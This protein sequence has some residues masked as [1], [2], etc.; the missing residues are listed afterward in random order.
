VASGG[1]WLLATPT[2][3]EYG[4][5]QAERPFEILAP[6]LPPVPWTSRNMLVERNPAETT[7]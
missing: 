1:F 2:R 5:S 7:R 6:V 3:D 4:W